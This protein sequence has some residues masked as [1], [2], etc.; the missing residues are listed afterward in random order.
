MNVQV[1][2]GLACAG[3]RVDGRAIARFRES[4]LVGH[5]RRYPQEVA[6]QGFITLRSVV[7]RFYMLVWNDE[8]MY[9]RLRVDVS[10]SDA[11]LIPVS[12]IG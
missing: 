6:E 2:D 3:A 8:Q 7:Q 1:K 5:A 9:G 4:L 11:A 12:N 10:K